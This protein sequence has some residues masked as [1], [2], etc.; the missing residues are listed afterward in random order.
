MLALLI[1][2]GLAIATSNLMA[3]AIRKS[4][5]RERLQEISTAKQK[6]SN[7]KDD[8]DRQ[9]TLLR[10]G[11]LITFNSFLFGSFLVLLMLPMACEV[12]SF[13]FSVLEIV[14]HSVAFCIAIV[15]WLWISEKLKR[16]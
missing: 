5:W 9:S 7:A 6:F 2:V 16:V 10:M 15:A 8:D 11:K 3:A 4:S 14:F 12:W 1:T 13:H